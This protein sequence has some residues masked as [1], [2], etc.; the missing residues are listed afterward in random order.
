MIELKYKIK[1]FQEKITILTIE[2]C[3]YDV[4]KF[5]LDLQINSDKCLYYNFLGYD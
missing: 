4:S 2:N 1:G 3:S 5:I